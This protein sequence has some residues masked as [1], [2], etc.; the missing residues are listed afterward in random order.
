MN[1]NVVL[2]IVLLSALLAGSG[3][4]TDSD[5]TGQYW[6]NGT[7]QVAMFMFKTLNESL[8]IYPDNTF[9]YTEINKKAIPASGIVTRNGDDLVFTSTLMSFRGTLDK[10]GSIVINEGAK[11]IKEVK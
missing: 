1:L 3:C 2:I 7:I 8:T 10:N 4:I 6:H 5:I 11:F 9:Y